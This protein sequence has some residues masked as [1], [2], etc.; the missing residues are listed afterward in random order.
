MARLRWLGEPSQ[1][2]RV[3]IH[4]ALFDRGAGVILGGAEGTIRLLIAG[5]LEPPPRVCKAACRDTDVAPVP[6]AAV[7]KFERFAH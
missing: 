7:F 6:P 4:N 3:E 1:A 5:H 2:V